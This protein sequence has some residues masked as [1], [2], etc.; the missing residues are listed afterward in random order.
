MCD[1]IH[2]SNYNLPQIFHKCGVLRRFRNK[3][4]VLACHAITLR[5]LNGVIHF[6]DFGGMNFFVE[7]WRGGG[8]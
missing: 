6:W 2:V 1:A 7:G 3:I 4:E 8:G 5:F